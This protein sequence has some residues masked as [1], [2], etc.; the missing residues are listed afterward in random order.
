[1]SKYKLTNKAVED[2]TQIWNYT[3]VKWSLNQASLYYEM[4]INHFSLIADKPE[5]GKSYSKILENL[6]GL[7]AGRHIIFY[8]NK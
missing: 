8:K 5:S 4:L 6:M 1:M 3:A 7:K 2:L